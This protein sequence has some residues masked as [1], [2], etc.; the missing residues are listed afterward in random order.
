MET[1]DV[2][3]EAEEAPATENGETSSVEPSSIAEAVATN[4]VEDG[5][6]EAE[7]EPSKTWRQHPESMGS[8]Y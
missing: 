6:T 1:E 2:T 5:V 4:A 7:V 3:D 8:F